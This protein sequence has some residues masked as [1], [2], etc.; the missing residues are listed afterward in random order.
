MTKQIPLFKEGAEL[1]VRAFGTQLA[2]AR[3]LGYEDL[4]N[5]SPWASG[6]RPFTPEHCYTIERESKGQVTRQIL[7]PHDFWKIWPDL[8][9]LAP[10]E[11]AQQAA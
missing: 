10:Q 6:V 9:H 8:A 1:A 3:V 5:I 2:L 7:R 4:R 11:P